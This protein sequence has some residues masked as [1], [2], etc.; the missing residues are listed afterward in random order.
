L[1]E[2]ME[3]IKACKEEDKEIIIITNEVGWGLVSEY[4]LGRIFTD[5]VGRV[6]QRVALECDEVYLVACGLPMRLK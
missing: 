3:I 2:V 5:I 4:K 1:K 6:N